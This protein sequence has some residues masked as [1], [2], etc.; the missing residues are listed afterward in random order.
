MKEGA[1]RLDF[2]INAACLLLVSDA[3]TVDLDMPGHLA[4]KLNLDAGAKPELARPINKDLTPWLLH[5]SADIKH[6]PFKQEHLW[7]VER[8]LSAGLADKAWALLNTIVEDNLVK[9]CERAYGGKLPKAFEEGG[10]Q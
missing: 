10:A 4:T 8:A 1:R 2:L 6:T 9:R 5:P 3:S 7:P